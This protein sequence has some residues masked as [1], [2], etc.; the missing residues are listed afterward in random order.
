[1]YG[2]AFA[3]LMCTEYLHAGIIIESPQNCRVSF[4]DVHKFSVLLTP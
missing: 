3:V 2:Y 4:L 1:M